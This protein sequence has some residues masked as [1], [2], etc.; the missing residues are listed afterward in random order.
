MPSIGLYIF[1]RDCRIDDNPTLALIASK[2]DFLVCL[3]C[4]QPMDN[5]AKKFSQTTSSTAQRGYIKQNVLQLNYQLVAL[6]QQLIV[7]EGEFSHL[8][9]QLITFHH[10]S[11]IA[12]SNSGGSYEQSS[13]RK[14]QQKY[15]AI[16]FLSTDANSLFDQSQLPFDIAGLPASFTTFRKLV[17]QIAQKKPIKVLK[18]LPPTPV[19]LIFMLPDTLTQSANRY[20]KGG[21]LCAQSHLKYYFS[22]HA[23]SRYK[24]SRNALQGDNFSTQFSPYLAHGALSPRQIMQALNEYEEVHGANESSYWIY[25]ELLWREY[26]YW[27]GRKHQQRLFW[28]SGIN[29]NKPTLDFSSNRFTDWCCG[30]TDFALVNALMHQLNETGWMSNRGRQIVASCLVN[31]LGIDWRYGAGYFEQRLIDYDV[32][33]N[34]GNWQYIV[35][36]GADPRG[37]RHFNI[38]KQTQIYDADGEFV[39]RW[40]LTATVE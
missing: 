21:E 20:F 8:V 3:Y 29:E 1:D 15:P 28:L 38:E 24:D 12:R 2:V 13:W 33:S 18:K 23:A 4:V 36:V 5:F 31:E 34:W 14:L 11:H 10:I 17:E 27:Y 37:G 35:G 39:A 7:A 16:T 19:E 40:T 6:G 9:E 22:T 26:F 30:K 32:T 25:F